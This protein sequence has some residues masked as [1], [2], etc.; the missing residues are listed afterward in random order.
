MDFTG[1][2]QWAQRG[3]S[4]MLQLNSSRSRRE[5][6][7]VM[8]MMIWARRRSWRNS[9]PN[10]ESCYVDVVQPLWGHFLWLL[11]RVLEMI[12]I[13]RYNPWSNETYCDGQR[14]KEEAVNNLDTEPA[15]NE[16]H[17]P[18]N[19]K[20]QIHLPKTRRHNPHLLC[21]IPLLIRQHNNPPL[22]VPDLLHAPNRAVT[23]PL[24]CLC[25]SSTVWCAVLYRHHTVSGHF[26]N[27]SSQKGIVVCSCL[28]FKM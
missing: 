3:G 25:W 21:S 7:M 26:F 19:I 10:C 17:L 6:W 2:K 4:L 22:T 14:N 15:N 13:N 24:A 28:C 16:H 9:G 23:S 18:L 27:L 20:S 8:G 11:R 12:M 5:T 1:S